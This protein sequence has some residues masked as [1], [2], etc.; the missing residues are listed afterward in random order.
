M[1]HNDDHDDKKNPFF[2]LPGDMNPMSSPFGGFKF[3]RSMLGRGINQVKAMGDWIIDQGQDALPTFPVEAIALKVFPLIETGSFINVFSLFSGAKQPRRVI[4]YIPELHAHIPMWKSEAT[5][6]LSEEDRIKYNKKILSLISDGGGSF[7]MHADTPEFG[8]T[9]ITAGDRLLVDYQDRKNFVGGRV[10]KILEKND[11]NFL[12]AEWFNPPGT[13]T[14]G[15]DPK[16]AIETG[17]PVPLSEVV[18]PGAVLDVP[19]AVYDNEQLD[20]DIPPEFRPFLHPLNGKSNISSGTPLR[21][22][23]T[24]THSGIDMGW[25][26]LPIYAM[27]DGYVHYSTQLKGELVDKEVSASYISSGYIK[28]DYETRVD[29]QGKKTYW[30]KRDRGMSQT[31]G[32]YCEIKHWHERVE[33]HSNGQGFGGNNEKGY[34]T[35][36]LHQM[37]PPLVKSGEKVKRGQLLGYV[38]GTPFFSPHIHLDVVYKGIY[39]DPGPYVYM[40]ID[41][42]AMIEDGGNGHIRSSKSDPSGWVREQ[43]NA[44]KGGRSGKINYRVGTFITGQQYT[45]PKT[46]KDPY[47]SSSRQWY[48]PVSGNPLTTEELTFVVM[49]PPPDLEDDLAAKDT[50]NEKEPDI[51]DVPQQAIPEGK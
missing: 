23:K 14:T 39:V 17:N 2:P 28:E 29:E 13:S 15:V 51:A 45:W 43:F 35:R 46:E 21:N 22:T 7:I 20:P 19:P 40:D 12:P 16:K 31:A 24:G 9:D 42:I 32:W 37:A 34:G 44:P 48:K 27:A 11:A 38:G 36:Y 3:T 30:V 47:G 5:S 6:D 25:Q 50:A 1:S 8:D 33:G 10:L 18:N 26:P 41:A 49:Q 4:C